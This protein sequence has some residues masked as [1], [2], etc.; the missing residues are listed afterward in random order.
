MTYILKES[1][2]N[3]QLDGEELRPGLIWCEIVPHLDVEDDEALH[4]YRG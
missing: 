2:E 4:G 3:D 1:E